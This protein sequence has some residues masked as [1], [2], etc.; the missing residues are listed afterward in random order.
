MSFNITSAIKNLLNNER[1]IYK[2]LAVGDALERGAGIY[3]GLLT[4]VGGAAAEDFAIEGVLPTDVVIVTLNTPGSSAVTV[5]SA[6]CDT[7]KITVTFSGD[8]ADD[9]IINVHVLRG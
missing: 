4:T 7:D 3:S 1:I 2:Q 5:D 9:H 8:P 6:L